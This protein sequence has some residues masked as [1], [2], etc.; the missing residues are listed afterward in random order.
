MAT[1]I[2]AQRITRFIQSRFNPIRSLTPEW[3]SRMIDGFD[4]GFLREFAMMSDAIERRDDLLMSV[5]PKR[6]KAIGRHGYEIVTINQSPA[7][8]KHKAALEYFYNHLTAVNAISENERGGFRLL[9][10]QMADAIGKKYAVH[11]IIW[12]PSPLGLTAE[13][14]FAPLWFFENRLGRLRYLPTEGAVDGIELDPESWMISV[15]DGLMLPCAIAY[16]FKHLPLKDWLI[17]CERFGMPIP[18]GETNAPP[19]SPE[20]KNMVSAVESIMAGAAAVKNQG[21]NIT[22]LETKGATGTLPHPLLVERMDRAMSAMWRGSDLSTMSRGGERPAG[23]MPQME[24]SEILEVD[25]TEWVSETLN[26][27]VDRK[28]IAFAIG[29]SEPLAYIKVL[30]GRRQDT[31]NDILVDQFLIDTGFPIQLQTLSERYGR[32]LP[33]GV[34]GNAL[35]KAPGGSSEPGAPGAADGNPKDELTNPA[36]RQTA[37]EKQLADLLANSNGRV[38]DSIDHLV[39]K[40]AQRYG[41]ARLQDLQPLTSEL[42]RIFAMPSEVSQGDALKTLLRTMPTV[43]AQVN[44][45]PAAAPVLAETMTAA[46]FNGIDD[47]A[48]D[49]KT[50]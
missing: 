47:A 26:I 23:A 5:A 42:S 48:I 3:L 14:R 35:L 43:A 6:K 10:K 44:K 49:R 19:D 29:D 13:F 1:I 50:A 4:A 28:V 11:E 34:D 36:T 27:Q 15:G 30:N 7:A 21:E 24:E 32:P 2:T 45:K 17:Y 37:N 16:M 33:P 22:L 39:S 25:D 18:I 8:K 46:L 38:V 20:W 12:K 31:Q 41:T 9:I 40:S